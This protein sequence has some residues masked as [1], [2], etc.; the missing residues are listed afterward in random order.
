MKPDNWPQRN[1]ALLQATMA[2]IE[3]N[4]EQHD[5]NNW[6]TACGT[7][8]CYAG[9]AAILAGA[10]RPGNEVAEW[11][12]SWAINVETL[13]SLAVESVSGYSDTVKPIDEFAAARLGLT[14]D[15]ADV[16]FD[17]DQTLRTLRILVDAL[18]A[19]AWI[20]E[21]GMIHDVERDFTSCDVNDWL[22]DFI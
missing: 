1:V 21:N 6:I 9:H 19:D 20:D 11:G 16:L 7:A 13:E 4:P 2:Y 18:C 12:R 22:I 10:A 3:K 14:L 15:E 8:F 17:G 5:Q